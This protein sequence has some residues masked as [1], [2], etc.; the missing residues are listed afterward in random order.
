MRRKKALTAGAFAVLAGSAVLLVTTLIAR[1]PAFIHGAVLASD[2]DPAKELPIAG[3]EVTLDGTA[4]VRSDAS[5]L[6]TIPL[7]LQERMRPG[8]RVT[9]YFR[10][11]DYQPLELRDIVWDKLCVAHLTPAD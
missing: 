7:P 9:L 10:H 2:P 8:V 4:T 1:H 6:F 5:G 3:A 11:S